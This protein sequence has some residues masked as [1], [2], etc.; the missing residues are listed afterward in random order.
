M[1]ACAMAAA[2]TPLCVVGVAAPA[3]AADIE[4]TGAPGTPLSFTDPANWAGNQVPG[5][6]DNA[7]INNGGVATLSTAAG[8]SNLRLG[9][10]A[11]T[12]GTMQQSSG[13]FNAGDQIRVGDAG[14]GT[15]VLSGGTVSHFNEFM[16]G[17]G[18]GGN[19]TLRI[20]GG[21]FNSQFHVIPGAGTNSVG[22][23]VQT[24]GHIDAPFP[25]VVATANGP[26]STSTWD[27]SAGTVTTGEFY[28]GANG[29]GTFNLSGTGFVQFAVNAHIGAGPTG[30]GTFV[31][32]GG[33]ITGTNP[34]GSHFLVGE[35]GTAT[36][37]MSGG[38]INVPRLNIG[39]NTNARGTV[40]QT[41]GTVTVDTAVVLGEVSHQANLY[42]ISGG[43]LNA[44]GTTNIIRVASS[45]AD[46]TM[47]I[48]DNAVVRSDN[49]MYVGSGAPS[50]GTLTM[51]GGS[52]TLGA[53]GSGDGELIVGVF[54]NGTA[55]ITGGTVTTDFIRVA[56]G[57]AAVGTLNIGG[58]ANVTVAN[59]T[60]TGQTYEGTFGGVS[61]INVSGGNFTAGTVTGP[62]TISVSGGTMTANSIQ[63]TTL[64]VTGGTVGIAPN[65]TATGT[66]RVNTLD[67]SGTGKVDLTNNALVI[68]YASADPS[69]IADVRA[70]IASAFAGGAW[71]GPGLTS[72]SA[73]NTTHGLGFAEASSLTAVDPIFGTVDADAVLVRYTRYGDANLDGTV[74]LSDF[75]R[76]ASNFGASNAVWGQGD[77]NYDGSVNLSDFN[78]LASNFGLSAAGPTV[79]PDDWARLGAAVPEPSSA[80]L[81]GIGALVSLRRRRNR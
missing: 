7:L 79:T 4:W 12:S 72:S 59:S 22:N 33:S 38:N 24:G 56:H 32:T 41:G 26:G 65:G 67:I 54:G 81:L 11:G 47:V 71:S 49:D 76:L 58:T 53:G 34:G 70:D 29:N 13:A 64:A 43:T 68:D 52:L 80:A 50:F 48:R 37:L 51:S 17:A 20:S 28:V 74:N 25:A 19:G 8:V 14:T 77:F 55:N 62:G 78:R 2:A 42:D 30:V 69:P 23:V 60:I 15:Y 73:N 18:V 40:Q 66:S 16:L 5:G 36:L 1:L 27:M 63:Q 61:R 46:A 31:M 3:V 35:V 45:N 10:T 9:V 39:Q 44:S 21:T 57:T 75:N 6:A